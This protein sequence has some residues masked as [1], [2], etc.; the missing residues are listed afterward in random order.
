MRIGRGL[1]GGT[2]LGTFNDLRLSFFIYRYPQ[3]E[4]PVWCEG[5]QVAGLVDLAAMK[6]DAISSRGRKRDFIDLHHICQRAF[7]LSQAI[8]FFEQRYKGVQYSREGREMPVIIVE[9]Y[10]G[11]T[12]EQKAALAKKLTAG[13]IEVLGVRPDQVRVI[14]HDLPKEDYAVGGKTIA[15]LQREMS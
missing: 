15:E 7:P 11:R 2:F 3:L 8:A 10:T 4:T 9:M 6:L 1:P 5:I 13:T 14:I 12:T